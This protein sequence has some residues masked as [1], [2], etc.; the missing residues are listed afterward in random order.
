MIG[1]FRAAVE[2][3]RRQEQLPFAALLSED[4]IQR[5]LGPARA[6]WQGWIYT[7]STTV[8]VFLSQCLSADHSCREAV[9]RLIGWRLARGMKACSAETGAYCAARGQLPEAACQELVRETGRALEREAPAEWLWH[10]RQ[11]RCVDGTTFTMPDTPENQA[12]Y[13]Q[14]T[15]QAP[16]CGFPI[17]RLVVIFSLAVGTVLEGALGPYRGKQTGENSLFRQLHHT[18]EPGDVV[19]ADR[20][21]SGWFD[22]A[23]LGQRDIDV[24]VRKHQLRKT[25]FRTGLRLGKDDHLVTWSKPQRP[26][27]MTAD[28]FAALPEQLLLREVRI[29]VAQRGFRTKS[30]VVVT[31]LLDADEFPPQDIAELYRQR[32][33]AELHLRSLKVVLQVDH[34]RCKTPERVRNELWMHLVAYNLIR[35]V[36]ATAALTNGVCPWTISFKG[37]LQT[38]HQFLPLLAAVPATTW[39]ATL[40]TAIATHTVGN[41]LDRCEP[42]LVK[43]RPKPYKFLTK[44]RRCYKTS[45]GNK[46]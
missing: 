9:A 15:N 37:T 32:W 42:R 4:A 11:V 27:W 35:R 24:V 13:P 16:G 6:L 23:L 3:S 34:L 10:G 14:Q 41:R 29:R 8:W 31:T 30:L 22:L 19:L 39:V 44:P 46:T 38:L 33:Q 18:L 25:D 43:R 7:P 26:K 40:L 12:E 2:R 21:F 5:A 20:Y 36:M 45:G 17:A 28:V 1:A